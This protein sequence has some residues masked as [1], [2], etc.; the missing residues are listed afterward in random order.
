MTLDQSITQ[1]VLTIQT[2][3][4]STA[5]ARRTHPV[6]RTLCTVRAMVR[7]RHVQS[8]AGCVLV[9]QLDVRDAE[10]VGTRQRLARAALTYVFYVQSV[11]HLRAA[12]QSARAAHLALM[13][14]DQSITQIVLTIQTGA[15]STADARR[16]HPV[17]RT[18]CT[19]RAMVR[20]R[21]VQS[22]VVLVRYARTS[23][24][25][26]PGKSLSSRLH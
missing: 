21:H 2:G 26:E 20:W 17:A 12:L 3:A 16:T 13:T 24:W 5:D 8:H 7:W 6:A 1:I 11:S 4:A 14:L 10:L 18:L 9:R 25:A 15:A 22:H 23:I 19:V